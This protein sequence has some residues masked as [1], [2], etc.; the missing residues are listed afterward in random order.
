M[1]A[2]RLTVQLQANGAGEFTKTIQNEVIPLLR[3]Q[4]GFK[5]ELVLINPKSSQAESISLWNS[6]ENAENFGK[7]PY[8]DMLRLL[9]NVIKDR[10]QVETYQVANSTIHN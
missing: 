4:P 10:P 2:R 7:G 8:M 5:D 9:G 3:K 1:F 6:Q